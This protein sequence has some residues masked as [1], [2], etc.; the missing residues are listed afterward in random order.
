MSTDLSEPI[1]TPSVNPELETNREIM[2]E[3]NVV[4]DEHLATIPPAE[5]IVT[6]PTDG[7]PKR[8]SNNS[9]NYTTGLKKTP[10]IQLEWKNLS[11]NVNVRPG[12][13][14]RPVKKTILNNLS[15]H[16]SPGE[17]LAIMGPSGAGKTSLLNILAQRVRNYQGS[18]IINGKENDKTAIRRLKASIAFVQQDDVL[19]G[20][21]NVREALVYAALLRLPSSMTLREKLERVDQVIDELGLTKCKYTKIGVPGFSK[22]ISG[23][24]RKRLSI[25]IELLTGPSILFL[26]EPTTG[27]DAKTALNIMETIDKLAKSGRAVVLTIHQPRS[28]IYQMFDRLLLLSRGKTAYFGK[29]HEA[30]RYFA[31]IGYVCPKEYNPADYIIDLVAEA[32]ALESQELRDQQEKR[33]VSV[34]DAY[35]KR[36]EEFEAPPALKVDVDYDMSKVTSYASS[37]IVQF[38]VLFVRSFVN[39]IRD[40]MLTFARMF[41]TLSMSII[42][43][44]IYLRIDY[45]QSNAQDRIGVLFFILLNQSMGAIFGSVTTFPAELAVFLRE[46]GAK[47]YHVSSYYLA[48]I[49]AEV[50]HSLVF[51][52]I[53]SCISY[54]MVGLNPGA[55]R[56]FIH[57]LIMIVVIFAAQSFGQLISAIAPRPEIALAITPVITTLLMLFGG[58]YMN[59]NN[60]PPYVIWIYWISFFHFG[61]EAL[62]LNEFRGLTFKCKPEELRGPQKICPIENGDQVIQNLNMTG[63]LSNIWINIGFMCAII[64]ICKVLTFFALRFLRKPKAA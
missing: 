17:V 2:P 10:P 7:E 52:I 38:L 28:D 56:F 51:P 55:D 42:V 45:F 12:C 34:L 33:I 24:E 25:A 63:T 3:N 41:Q 14:K 58:F 8:A 9:S 37:W 47:T 50:P 15:G 60:I 48:K 54:W 22:G 1:S 6:M 19:M 21:L 53:F 4:V 16:I 11:Y 5:H 62:V 36:R 46:R 39:I 26:D 59:V 49:C 57:I 18:L 20:N 30:T 35:E 32:P 61:F 64:V 27:L 13:F 44:L 40:G 29:A 43:G 31:D 23:G